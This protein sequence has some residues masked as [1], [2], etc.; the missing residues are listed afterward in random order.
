MKRKICYIR[1]YVRLPT[2]SRKQEKRNGQT[3]NT[4]D[5]GIDRKKKKYCRDTAWIDI[6]KGKNQR[7]I[8][9][10]NFTC[11][12]PMKALM[13]GKYKGLLEEVLLELI[14]N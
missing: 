10:K 13:H 5:Q 12:S 7:E 8:S 3:E 6:D 1:W 9:R 11:S 2:G 14:V 4:R